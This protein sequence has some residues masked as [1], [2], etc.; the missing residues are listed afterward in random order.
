MKSQTTEISS[1][2][3]F[4]TQSCP[5]LCPRTS[6]WGWAPLQVVTEAT[7][8]FGVLTP[9]IYNHHHWSQMNCKRLERTGVQSPLV[10]SA[11]V[12]SARLQTKSISEIKLA[13]NFLFQWKLWCWNPPSPLS[14]APSCPSSCPFVHCVLSTLL[15][16]A[17]KSQ[18][19]PYAWEKVLVTV[20]WFLFVQRWGQKHLL[21]TDKWEKFEWFCDNSSWIYAED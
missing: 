9:C 20:E 8:G 21:F 2:Y 3:V 6:S 10:L 19:Q 11:S 1:K 14:P 13:L 12:L 7:V 15:S 5:Q 18:F 16:D 17:S 4:W